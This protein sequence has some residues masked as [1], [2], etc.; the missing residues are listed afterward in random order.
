[1]KVLVGYTGFVGS[2][3]MQSMSFDKYFNSTN[4]HQ[5]KH[6]EVDEL[7]FCGVPAVK[8]YANKYPEEDND[9]LQKIKAILA[10]MKIKKFILISTID[11]YEDSAGKQ[12]ED[13]ECDIFLNNTYGRNRY[14]F[15]KFVASLCA[16]H[17]ILRLPA[18][19]GKGLKKNILFDL[20]HENQL[21]NISALTSF[22]WYDLN[23]LAN[24][25]RVVL[26]HNLRICNLFTEPLDTMRILSFFPYPAERFHQNGSTLAYDIRTKYAS[27]FRPDGQHYIRTQEEVLLNIQQFIAFQ[28]IS[29]EHLVVSNICVKKTSH[30]QLAYVLKLFGIKHVQIAPTTLISDWDHLDELDV[31][32]FTNCG[33]NVYSMQSITYGLT[34]NVF[35]PETRDA[36][37]TH[38]QKVVDVA[39]QKGVQILVFGCPRNRKSMGTGMWLENDAFC[40]FFRALGDY[41]GNREVGGNL[42]ICIEPNSKQYGCNYLTTIAEAGKIVRQIDHPKIRLMVDIGN[43]QMEKEDLSVVYEYADVICNVDIA[44]EK[45]VD[46]RNP[47]PENASFPTILRN[48]GYHHKINLEMILQEETCEMELEVLCASLTNFIRGY[49]IWKPR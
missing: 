10:Q 42:K 18:L 31:S 16:D 9:V 37:K 48:I 6:L 40:A 34:H 30:F 3:L 19:F 46:F 39:I 21:E 23:W 2:N 32:V 11:V 49:G 20:L 4:F 29:R 43:A 7:Y 27:L 25:I 26:K 35:D 44:Q 13:Y 5:A 12:D 1:M 45:M 36:L 14:L 28:Q 17:H 8:W 41:I 33:L 24:D 22:Q 15:E 38:L 47:S